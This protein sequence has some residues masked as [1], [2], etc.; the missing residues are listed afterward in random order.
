MIPSGIQLHISISYTN[1]LKIISG[2][3]IENAKFIIEFLR[4]FNENNYG[5][6]VDIEDLSHSDYVKIFKYVNALFIKYPNFNY[7]TKPKTFESD[8]DL[9]D[10]VNDL[11]G[12]L[13]GASEDYLFKCFESVIVYYISQTITEMNLFTI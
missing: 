12:E 6:T 2:L 5:N 1:E 13:L 3:S 9:F 7:L 8:E 10:Y 11:C 4:L